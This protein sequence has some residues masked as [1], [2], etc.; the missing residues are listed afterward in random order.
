MKKG[1]R[2]DLDEMKNEKMKNEKMLGFPIF[3]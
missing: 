1:N 2:E 3:L